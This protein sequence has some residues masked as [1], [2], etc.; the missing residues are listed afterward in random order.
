MQSNPAGPYGSDFDHN[1]R[2]DWIAPISE[3]G[4]F[5]TIRISARLNSRSAENGRQTECSDTQKMRW[6]HTDEVGI[7]EVR[8]RAMRYEAMTRFSNS[9]SLL[10]H[11]QLDHPAPGFQHYIR[12]RLNSFNTNINH[13]TTNNGIQH[14]RRASSTDRKSH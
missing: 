9:V 7:D 10:T 13:I 5:N 3:L 14:L 8:C 2:L 6:M 12:A 11:L 1:M 4:N